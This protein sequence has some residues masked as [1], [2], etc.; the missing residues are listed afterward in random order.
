VRLGAAGRNELAANRYGERQ[1]GKA[2]AVEV[3]ELPPSDA[4][5]DSA[6]AM[7]R[8]A[9]AGPRRDFPLDPFTD[10]STHRTPPS[11][12]LPAMSGRVHR[13]RCDEEH[14]IFPARLIL[15]QIGRAH[16]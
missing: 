4:E 14:R 5:L 2:V 6:V 10:R 12:C 13:T 1:V 9:D 16:V 15:S 11:S 3:A 7:R 8:H